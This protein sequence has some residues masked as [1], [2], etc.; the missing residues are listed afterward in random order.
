MGKRY[1]WN[2]GNSLIFFSVFLF[3][4][5]QRAV[6]LVIA[7]RN[8]KLLLA[9]G[10]YEV[11]ASHY[12]YI[13]ILHIGFLMSLLIEVMY[14]ATFS[15]VHPLLLVFFLVVQCVRIWCIQSLGVYWNTKIIVLRGADVVVRGPYKF[16]RHPNYV[17]VCL[18]ILLLPVMFGAYFTALLFTALNL[19]MLFIRI[20]LEEEA[21]TYATNYTEAMNKSSKI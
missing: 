12:P 2:G 7:R 5:L 6:E 18:E 14:E 3:V 9:K 21:L 17:I 11:G 20:P 1:Y 10:A 19:W 15:L 16:L 4:L 13:V 8:E